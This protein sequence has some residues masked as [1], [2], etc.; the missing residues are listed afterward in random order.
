M[1]ELELCGQFTLNEKKIAEHSQIISFNLHISLWVNI[2]LITLCR[3]RNWDLKILICPVHSYKRVPWNLN[4]GPCDSKILHSLRQ[5]FRKVGTVLS[6]SV[7]L[8][9][10]CF[11][12]Y[13]KQR[14]IWTWSL[15][16]FSALN[17]CCCFYNTWSN[18]N[19]SMTW[20]VPSLS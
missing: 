18:Q 14:G 15:T 9:F 4:P 20:K 16:C 12:S 6:N 17:I 1:S 3:C 19:E 7:S 5:T 8:D 10:T 11:F 13:I 2:F